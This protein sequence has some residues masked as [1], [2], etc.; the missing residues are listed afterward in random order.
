MKNKT[1]S[2]FYEEL[3]GFSFDKK[4]AQGLVKRANTAG[5]DIYYAYHEDGPDTWKRGWSR[6]D[7]KNEYNDVTIFEATNLI[8]KVK[9]IGS[10][11]KGSTYTAECAI[12]VFCPLAELLRDPILRERKIQQEK[13][14][15]SKHATADY[16]RA[17]DAKVNIDKWQSLPEDAKNEIAQLQ[18]ESDAILGQPHSAKIRAEKNRRIR[19]LGGV[20]PALSNWMN[21]A[22]SFKNVEDYIEYR[23]G[24]A[25]E[26]LLKE[27]EEKV[28]D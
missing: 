24:T 21:E 12:F 9:G 19:E 2:D 17:L 6:D 26:L 5:Y 10:F 14:K 13:N 11:K 18:T 23:E 15:V 7:Y 1:L 27:T 8:G 4:K 22:I 28:E 3:S 25:V 16:E 20:R